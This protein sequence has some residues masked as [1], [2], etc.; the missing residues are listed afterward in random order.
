MEGTK[1]IY[2][3]PDEDAGQM[4]PGRV[5][6]DPKKSRGF[7]FTPDGLTLRRKLTNFAYAVATHGVTKGI[8]GVSGLIF[9]F[10]AMVL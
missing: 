10:R 6:M 7:K 1:K 4:V 3:S 2:A 9:H 8:F 5:R